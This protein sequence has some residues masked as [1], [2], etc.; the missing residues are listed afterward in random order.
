MG[1]C[2]FVVEKVREAAQEPW[3][4]KTV[5][6]DGVR[7]TPARALRYDAKLELERNVRP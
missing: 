2:K 1:C 7:Q 6:S 3:M 5:K 4:G